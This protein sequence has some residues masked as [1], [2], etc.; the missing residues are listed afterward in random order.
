MHTHTVE[1]FNHFVTNWARGMYRGLRYGQAFCNV[2][3]VQDTELYYEVD[4]VKAAE[5]I[6]TYVT[7]WQI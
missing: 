7:G 6:G 1:S 5:R 4:Q 3:G 2:F